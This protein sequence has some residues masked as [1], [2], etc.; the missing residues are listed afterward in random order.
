MAVAGDDSTAALEFEK[1]DASL[2]DDEGVDLVYRTVVA[3]EL[4]IRVDE[5]W[6]T[7]RK[8]LTKE[9][10]GLALVRVSRFGELFP[11]AGR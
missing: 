10:E 2:G 11:A 8:G 1:E 3:D 4:E 7:I 6:I 5:D 9:I